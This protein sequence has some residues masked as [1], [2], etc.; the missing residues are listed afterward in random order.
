MPRQ[1]PSFLFLIPSF[2][3]FLSLLLTLISLLPSTTALSSYSSNS[4]SNS[5]SPTSPSTP[6]ATPSRPALQIDDSSESIYTYA[7]C[8]N[9]SAG[10][11]GTTGLR[12]LDGANEVLEGEMTVEIC[13]AFCARGDAT[14]DHRAAYRLAGLEYSRECWCGDKLNPLTVRLD[15]AACDLP[16][17]GANTTACGGA[18]KLSLYN[19]TAAVLADEEKSAAEGR[20]ERAWGGVLMSTMVL[21]LGFALR[22][23]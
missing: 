7:G 22:G 6:S 20:W 19:A 13:L 21:V 4:T 5:T 1:K 12:A 14:Q 10:L 16:C 15:D 23:L 18:L 2:L 11:P 17:D 3:P 8:W 9:E